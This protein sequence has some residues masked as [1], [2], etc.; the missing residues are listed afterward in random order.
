MKKLH[1]TIGIPAYNEEQHIASIVSAL[2][3]QTRDRYFLDKIIVVSDGSSDKT[4]EKVKGLKQPLVEVVD[5]RNRMGKPARMN[6]IFSMTKSEV[7]VI[8]DADLI[9]KSN[10]SIDELVCPF[11]NTGGVEL[12]SG[13]AYPLQVKTFAQKI[14]M[15]GLDMWETA[16]Q[17]TPGSEMYYC[18]GPVR[19]FGRKLYSKIIFP[20]SSADDV[21]P[22]L[23]AMQMGYGFCYTNKTDICY[24]LPT[25]LGD[26]IKQTTR[27]IKSPEIQ[28]Q[29]FG[30]EVTNKHFVIGTREKMLTVIGGMGTNPFWTLMYLFVVGYIRFLEKFNRKE[31]KAAWD[32]VLSTKRNQ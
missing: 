7:V 12:V 4:V 22:Y 9:I 19:A 8:L 27:F 13:Y 14:A 17:N 3:A 1:I 16:K 29:N 32:S 25:T 20:N 10:N 24:R 18:G 26:Y 15:A 21:Y 28:E 23:F 30:R 5:S 2:L 11:G 31:D 6:Q